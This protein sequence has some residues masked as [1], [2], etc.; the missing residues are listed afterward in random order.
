MYD[1]QFCG[2]VS[3]RVSRHDKAV[4]P[5]EK[6]LVMQCR[7]LIF[8]QQDNIVLSVAPRTKLF[9]YPRSDIDSYPFT[10]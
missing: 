1:T 5:R 9:S 6:H 4:Q 10:L 3:R 7:S 8:H 2:V